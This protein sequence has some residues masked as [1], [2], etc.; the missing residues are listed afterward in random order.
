[1][2]ELWYIYSNKNDAFVKSIVKGKEYFDPKQYYH[3]AVEVFPTD[4]AGHLMIAK[5]SLKKRKGSGKYEFPAGS[6]IANETP[7]NAARREL[8]EELGLKCRSMKK[9]CE[10]KVPGIKR[11]FFLAY[12]PDLTEQKVTLQEGENTD[13]QIITYNQ[14]FE[15]IS[16]GQFFQERAEMYTAQLFDNLEKFVGSLE[17]LPSQKEEN[18]TI[19]VCEGFP[20]K[21][22]EL[23]LEDEPVPEEPREEISYSEPGKEIDV[24][25]Y[26]WDGNEDIELSAD[27]G[28]E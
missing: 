10:V 6:V 21:K 8:K 14:L 26:I 23:T 2:E 17:T 22:I 4:K 7:A 25:G 15:L 16:R 24:G 27:P 12:I 1:M 11:Y 28:K 9:L 3:E 13:Y 5:R 18:R 20:G 19:R